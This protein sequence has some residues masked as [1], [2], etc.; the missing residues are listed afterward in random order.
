MNSFMTIN[1]IKT[2]DLHVSFERSLNS[3]DSANDFKLTK[4]ETI[5]AIWAHGIIIGGVPQYHSSS[6][7]NRGS[8]RMLIPSFDSASA[9]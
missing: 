7:M 4:G 9:L 1:S 6:T 2:G 3:G 8:F 5:D